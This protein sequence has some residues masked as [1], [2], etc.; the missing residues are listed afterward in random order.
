MIFDVLDHYLGEDWDQGET[1]GRLLDLSFARLLEIYIELN[2]TNFRRT[3]RY[4]QNELVLYLGNELDLKTIL[5]AVLHSHK[6]V[7][8]YPVRLH[9]R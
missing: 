4:P 7:V 1:F 2:T 5:C 9:F 6:V 3:T 8:D